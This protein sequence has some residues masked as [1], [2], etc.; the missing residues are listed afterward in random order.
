[1]STIKLKNQYFETITA[2]ANQVIFNGILNKPFP[3]KAGYWMGR[4]VDKIQ[5][6]SRI[7]FGA[8]QRLVGQYAKLDDKNNIKTNPDGTVIWSSETA[9]LGFIKE[10]EELQDIEIDLGM[11]EIEADFDQLEERG[12]TIS[13]IEAMLVPFLKPKKS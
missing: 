12:I 8:K 11:D 3:A 7:Y 9:A 4:V 2:K 5:S 1:M 13:P 6:Q 10:F